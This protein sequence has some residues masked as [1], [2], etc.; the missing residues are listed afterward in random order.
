M[1]TTRMWNLQNVFK[2][3]AGRFN[4]IQCVAVRHLEMPGRGDSWETVR[5]KYFAVGKSHIK[6]SLRCFFGELRI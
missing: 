5:R 6:N 3:A 4:S 2:M 1:T